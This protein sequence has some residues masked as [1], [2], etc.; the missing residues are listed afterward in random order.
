M[1]NAMLTALKDITEYIRNN[2]VSHKMG[3]GHEMDV[4]VVTPKMLL[5][6]EVRN[7]NRLLGL[8][9]VNYFGNKNGCKNKLI[10]K[11]Q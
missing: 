2:Y 11:N 1:M 10:T 9:K 4:W 5:S 3:K 7:L 6:K 8:R